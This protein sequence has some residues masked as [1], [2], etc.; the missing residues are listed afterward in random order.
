MANTAAK[1]QKTN[2]NKITQTSIVKG[3]PRETTEFPLNNTGAEAAKAHTMPIPSPRSNCH[4]FSKNKAQT[5]RPF[6]KPIARMA[7]S[8][9]LRSKALRNWDT[10]S[11]SVPSKSPSP[12][13]SWNALKYVF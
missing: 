5:N 8:S 7:A 2:P 12:P 10:P 3:P 6:G 13:K 11:P 1:T 9:L 4:P